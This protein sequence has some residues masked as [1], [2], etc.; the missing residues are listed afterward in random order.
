MVGLL[1][2]ASRVVPSQRTLTADTAQLQPPIGAFLSRQQ[3][4][5]GYAGKESAPENPEVLEKEK[6]R[7]MSGEKNKTDRIKSAPG[8]NETLSSESEAS[9]KADKD[10]HHDSIEDLQNHSAEVLK[11]ED[12]EK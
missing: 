8:W 10:D 9:V 12:S 2:H 6:S 4:V 3:T 5:R 1:R 11:K 7:Q